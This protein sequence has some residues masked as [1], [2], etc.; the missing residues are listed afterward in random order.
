MLTLL[1]PTAKRAS[2][3][4]TALQ[5]VA[6]QSAVAKIDRIVVSENGGSR[7][8]EEV[9]AQFP[10]L[11]ITYI[12][13]SPALTPLEHGRLLMRECSAGDY[14][15]VLHDDDWWAPT[16]LQC[17]LEALEA[18][19]DAS[20]YGAG[21]FVVAGESSM[22]NCSGNLFPWFGANYPAF[23]PWWK[24]SRLN[25]LM[26]ELLGTISHYSTLVARTA[27]LREASFIYELGNTFDNDR[28]LMFALSTSG[29]LLFNPTPQAFVRNHG[30]QDCFLFDHTT[31][32]RHMCGTTRWMIETS[33][34]S[35]DLIANTFAKRMAKCPENALPTLQALAL[36]EWCVPELK[37]NVLEPVLV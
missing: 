21:H 19:P 28:M 26:A 2:M 20:A 25:V 18:N 22:L 13:R 32:E 24:L 14:T 3:L 23:A 34:K 31:Q 11:P 27:A 1:L 16:H 29:P 10:A 17:A 8:S 9:C 33:G 12:F 7:E 37:R 5:S 30:V 4:R 6:G 36:K 15:A 35:W